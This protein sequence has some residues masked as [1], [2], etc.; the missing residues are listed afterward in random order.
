MLT[1]LIFASQLAHAADYYLESPS[2]PDRDVATHMQEQAKAG[3]ASARV[4][5][6]F[7]LGHGWEFVVLV[8]GLTSETAAGDAAKKLSQQ[9]GVPMTI[10]LVEE[11][12]KAVAVDAPPAAP[13]APAMTAAQWLA[14]ADAAL[15]GK[16]GGANELA[17]AAAVHF[18]YSRTFRLGDKDVTIH[19]DYWRE[20]PNRRLSVET[21]GAGQDSVAVVTSSGAWI[22]VN[23]SPTT[24][25]IGVSVEAVDGFAPESILTFALEGHRLLNAPEVQ[26][27]TVLEGAEAGLRLG[28]GSAD[29]DQGLTWLD[30]DP[31]SARITHARFVSEGGPIEW[32]LKDW[33][34]LGAGVVVPYDV[35]V[36]RTDGG[37]EHI[38][39]ERL[40]IVA[41][42][43]EGTFRSPVASSGSK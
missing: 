20:G 7:R 22:V 32:E 10:F 4:V 11:G 37:D 25:D 42:A 43:P 19:Q 8:E 16:A 9:L 38:R 1:L 39:V 17:R 23:G 28:S 2:I 36:E 31:T 5:R 34:Q 26:R 18:A 41:H 15:G 6:R 30:L 12:S 27:F 24:R 40:E 29:A 13:E 3:G 14:R 35:K 21:H 33:H